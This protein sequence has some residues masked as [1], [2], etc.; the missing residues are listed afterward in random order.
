MSPFLAA[1]HSSW[2][3]ANELAFALADGFP[4][5][6]GHT[7]VVT[8]RLVP[9]WFDATPA[10][11]AALLALVNDVRQLLD[12]TLHPKPDGYNVGFNSGAA[13]GQ[14]VPHVHVHVIPRYH[15]DVPDPRGGVRAVIPQL[16]NY[17]APPAAPPTASPAAPAAPAP[18]STPAPPTTLTTGH[19]DSP[20]WPRLASRLAGA[21]SVDILSSFVRLSG[22]DVIETALFAAVARGACIRI[23][24]S[25][26][27]GISD[28][29]ALQRL[30]GWIG[31]AEEA[32]PED[33]TSTRLHPPPLDVRLILTAELPN[34]PASFHPKAW[35]IRDTLESDSPDATSASSTSTCLVV[36][37]SNLSRAALLTGIEWN[38]VTSARAAPA[39]AGRF[40]AAF[41]ELWHVARPLTPAL[42]TDYSG[43][44]Q[45]LWPDGM[46]FDEPS[47]DRVQLVP[48]P[49]QERALASLLR[50]RESGCGRALAAVATGM[51]KTWLA[52]LDVRAV[53]HRL[54]RRPRI[55]IVAH[56]S[57]ILAQAEAAI[58]SLLDGEFGPA[59]VSWYLGS[60][61]DFSGELVIASI[62]KLCRPAGLELLEATRF[63]YAILD[64]VHHAQAPTWRRV[65][66]SLRAD[67]VLGLTATPE[68][69]D[70][71][72]V[73]TLFDDNLA[74]L[75]S[76]GDGIE[77]ESL[78]PFHYI[79][80]AD[81][82]EYSQIPWRS[83]RFDPAELERA[84]MTSARMERL[85]EAMQ[86][87]SGT[88]T[89][90]FCCSRRHASFTRDWLRSRGLTA[91]AVFSGTGSDPLGESLDA[92]RNGTLTSL[93]AVDLFNEGLDIPA[94]D[95]IVM[96]RPTESKVLFLQQLGRGLRTSP[97][98]QRLLVLDFVGNHRTFASRLLHLL[99][100]GNHNAGWNGVRNLVAGS[101]PPLPPGCLVDLDLAAR[102]LLQEFLPQ[103]AVAAR[104]AYRQWRDDNQ[105][106]PTALE[107]FRSGHRPRTVAAAQDGW[108]NFVKSE[109]DLTAEETECLAAHA[110][111]F[112]MLET[113]ALNRS[114]KMIVLRVLLDRDA[115]P[116]GLPLEQLSLA[117]RRHL[118]QHQ[119]LSRDVSEQAGLSDAEWC[120]W[121]KK[122]PIT[123]W[124]DDQAGRTWFHLQSNR[125][126]FRPSIAPNLITSFIRLTGELIDWRIA[127]YCASRGL[128][129]DSWGE[130]GTW[131]AAVSHVKGKPILFLPTVEKIPGRP[132][133][134]IDV[135]LPDGQ[136]WVFRCVKVACN[137]A[138]PKGA[139]GNQ[140][141]QLLK[142][143]FGPNVGLPG[144]QFRVRF[145]KEADGWHVEPVWPSDAG[146]ITPSA[147]ETVPED[148]E[149]PRGFRRHISAAEQH[150]SWVPVY[151]LTIAAG[152]WGP[153]SAP[154]IQGWVPITGRTVQSGMFVA[155]VHGESMQPRI[156]NG[157]WCL[158]RPCPAGTREGRLLLVQLRTESSAETGGRYTV[159]RYH[160]ERTITDEGWE[161]QSIALQ[162]INPDYAAIALTAE[163]AADV[164]INAEF[165]DMVDSE[166][167]APAQEATSQSR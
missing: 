28:P 167:S 45:R 9:T 123:R 17:L 8:R 57:Q 12:Q 81:T 85:W 131:E 71:V 154:E 147:S 130:G 163:T 148:T 79:G 3:V 107:F 117:C 78:V 1:P 24:V 80:I 32:A 47:G 161:H 5:S 21:A 88:R 144:T 153:E 91:A 51:G 152:F 162:P 127:A 126:R 31:A 36:G 76:I 145:R 92:L 69:A 122:W 46:A 119:V 115:I 120:T 105:R 97:G 139:S 55:L 65:L 20:L 61:N 39:A 159:K 27:L 11:Q 58:T 67:F 35:C 73:A 82:I 164:V 48:R 87:H 150:C 33:A 43:T 60:Q 141:P 52:A 63:D 14:T 29:R 108:L 109:G 74:C 124:L 110:D 101:P 15:G 94:V 138:S 118:Q 99:A 112:R 2:L 156:P 84:V 23:L 86:A 113:T 151:D 146:S 25:D 135:Q 160:S 19:P 30:L 83:G 149:R 93:C 166:P 90:F 4:V 89:I 111:W 44:V 165:V 59:Q 18:D 72:D 40:T 7:L 10:E 6:P 50:L 103:G 134:P 128:E 102:D 142:T 16:A 143:W 13:A 121:W 96:L 56:R 132:T 75:A 42:I 22:L 155:Q 125:F 68:R 66:A 114:Y 100:I 116:E 157:A 95:R 26:Y 54:R 64:E 140:L 37:S 38:L 41:T 62:Q 106:R 104:D 53:G 158:F 98:K 136:C 70:G 49:W 129:G 77:E 34:S 137:V 133:G